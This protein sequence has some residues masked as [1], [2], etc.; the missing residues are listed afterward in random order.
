MLAAGWGHHR[1]R[2]RLRRNGFAQRNRRTGWRR[3]E[4]KASFQN[5]SQIRGGGAFGRC[6]SGDALGAI[7][8]AVIYCIAR[9]EVT[10]ARVITAM[11]G[12]IEGILKGGEIPLNQI[13]IRLQAVHRSDGLNPVLSCKFL[14]L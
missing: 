1:R 7:D 13:T 5:T 14:V 11:K 6:S 12:Q 3:G 8:K 10:T 2:R 9:N 4:T